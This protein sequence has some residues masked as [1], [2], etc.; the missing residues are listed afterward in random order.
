MSDQEAEIFLR[1]P[2]SSYCL[3][4]KCERILAAFQDK[5]A[6]G[7]R[8]HLPAVKNTDKALAGFL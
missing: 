8:G 6:T 3:K 1:R 4:K 2:N 5:G 7:T